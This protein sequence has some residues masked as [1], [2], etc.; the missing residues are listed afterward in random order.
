MDD[1]KKIERLSAASRL[2]S[3][4]RDLQKEDRMFQGCLHILFNWVG[5]FSLWWCCKC[6]N[7]GWFNRTCTPHQCRSDESIEIRSRLPRNVRPSGNLSESSRWRATSGLREQGQRIA[8]LCRMNC[9]TGALHDQ[10]R[11][12]VFRNNV[13]TS[14]SLFPSAAC[15]YDCQ[16]N[17]L[18]SRTNVHQPKEKFQI[19]QRLCKSS[20]EMSHSLFIV[21]RRLISIGYDIPMP[22]RF[23]QTIDTFWRNLWPIRAAKSVSVNTMGSLI[24]WA[25]NNSTT[26]WTSDNCPPGYHQNDVLHFI[27][28]WSP[29]FLRLFC[30]S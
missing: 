8:N 14:D 20:L 12:W 26:N 9:L 3:A 2:Q 17:S 13:L 7:Q 22:I 15:R 25:R 29:I 21:R 27:L 19:F 10:Y 28:F 16:S 6:F 1:W 30:D 24:V 11:W 4:G 18:F 23:C 5:S